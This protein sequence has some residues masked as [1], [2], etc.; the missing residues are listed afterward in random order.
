MADSPPD[1]GLV[2]HAIVRNT[3]TDRA[4]DALRLGGPE[5]AFR[6]VSAGD[7]A[8]AVTDASFR[9][10]EEPDPEAL[11]EHESV[12][13]SLLRRSSVVPAPYGLLARNEASVRILLERGRA[14]LEEALE[15][16]SDTYEV[17]VHLRRA[18]DRPAG[19]ESENLAGYLRQ[20][21]G[22]LRGQAR[23]A[24]ELP[25]GEEEAVAAFLVGRG[26]WLQLVQEATRWEAR[27]PGIR[28]RVTGPWPPYDF[29]VVERGGAV[30]VRDGAEP[31]REDA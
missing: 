6:L 2:I 5:V 7:L 3:R 12:V 11:R 19:P 29:V 4:L 23:A 9:D 18:A 25:A 28:L 22:I 16:L 26:E 31:G 10:V 1:A 15:R 27:T 24:R 30:V 20:L 21:N 17:R 8:A 13:E 14:S